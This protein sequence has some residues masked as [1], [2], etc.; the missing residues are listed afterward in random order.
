[1]TPA[2]GAV[3]F[4][5]AYALTSVG[6]WGALFVVSGGP[7]GAPRGAA[8]DPLGTPHLAGVGGAGAGG[9]VDCQRAIFHW[10]FFFTYS[11][12]K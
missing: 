5:L 12:V 9:R 4:T 3:T 1:M 8:R 6:L 2:L 7:V 10:P 11:S